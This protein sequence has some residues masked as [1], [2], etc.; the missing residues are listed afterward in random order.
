MLLL[1]DFQIQCKID[2][3]PKVNH[4]IIYFRFIEKQGWI[5][6]QDLTDVF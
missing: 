6:E 5:Y 2:L 1:L 4:I 3:D